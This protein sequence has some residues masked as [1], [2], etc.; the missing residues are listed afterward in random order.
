MLG[1]IQNVSKVLK[2]LYKLLPSN[3]KICMVEYVDYFGVIP[4]VK[5]LNDIEHIEK[6]FKEAGFSV[7]VRKK[8]EFF[9][10]YVIISGIKISGDTVPYI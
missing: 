1:Y 5:W 6:V 8:K 10:T 3:G 4:N 2:E 9:W 7:H